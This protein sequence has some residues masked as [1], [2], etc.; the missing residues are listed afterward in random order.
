[1]ENAAPHPAKSAVPQLSVDDLVPRARDRAVVASDGRWALLPMDASPV[2]VA[3]LGDEPITLVPAD[4]Y[5]EASLLADD[6][7]RTLALLNSRLACIGVHD[8]QVRALLDDAG[9]DIGQAR[10]VASMVASAR[11]D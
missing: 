5:V 4:A 11:R 10:A 6:R 2:R 9:Y 8:P 7:G 3:G 1:M